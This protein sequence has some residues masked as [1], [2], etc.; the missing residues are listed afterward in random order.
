[1]FERLWEHGLLELPIEGGRDWSCQSID[2][3]TIKAPLS[4]EQT[5]ANPTNPGKIGTKRYLLTETSG[6]PISLLVTGATVHAK[7]QS[8]ALLA[9]MPFLPPLSAE[10]SYVTLLC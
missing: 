10:G 1:M 9:A 6:L 5:G 4:G 3:C 7:T 8:E 2:G